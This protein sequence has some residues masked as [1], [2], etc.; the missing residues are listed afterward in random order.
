[1]SWRPDIRPGHPLPLYAQIAEQL[2]QAIAS[3]RLGPGAPLP[4]LRELAEDLVVAPLTVKKAYDQLASEGLLRVQQG[5]GSFVN[6][7]LPRPTGAAGE[8]AL[9]DAVRHLLAEAWTNRIP[10]SRLLEMIREE[11]DSQP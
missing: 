3:G 1:M 5:R 2:R 7:E 9:R 10:I 6:E 4:G 11:A 8:A